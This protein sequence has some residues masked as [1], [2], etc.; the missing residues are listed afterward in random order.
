MGVNLANRQ[1]WTRI[2]TASKYG[3]VEVVKVLLG[4]PGIDVNRADHNGWTPLYAAT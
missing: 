4:V 3:D 1:G 2:Y